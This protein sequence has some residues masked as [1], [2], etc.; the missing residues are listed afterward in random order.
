M[1]AQ[2][3]YTPKVVYDGDDSTFEFPV[4]FAVDRKRDVFVE[5]ELANGAPGIMIPD[6]DYVVR[7]ETDGTLT[8]VTRVD[9]DSDPIATG[10]K[11]VIRRVMPFKQPTNRAVISPIVF[12]NR[13]DSLTREFQQLREQLDRTLH[14]GQPYPPYALRSSDSPGYTDGVYPALVQPTFVAVG[15]GD[16]IL[17]SR[18]GTVYA[19]VAASSLGLNWQDVAWNGFDSKFYAISTTGVVMRSLNS[20]ALEWETMG[21]IARPNNETWS[22]IG[23]NP[24][25]GTIIACASNSTFS[26]GA[27]ARSTNLGTSFSII[28]VSVAK[29]FEPLWLESHSQWAVSQIGATALSLSDDDGATWDLTTVTPYNAYGMGYRGTL[30]ISCDASGGGADRSWRT[31]NLTDFSTPSDVTAVDGERRAAAWG[32]GWFV[33]VGNGSAT[34]NGS[35]SSDGS[36]F[37][38]APVGTVQFHDIDFCQQFSMFSA[39]K[40]AQST[41]AIIYSLDNGVSFASASTPSVTQTSWIALTSNSPATLAG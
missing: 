2:N 13:L 11:I 28:E 16:N 5:L 12:R 37:A 24:N 32:D 20:K 8:V 25:T 17:V 33:Q 29:H 26:G 40:A 4:T 3:I 19:A 41:A 6:Q 21:T 22:G 30:L 31:A 39:L 15:N 1:T 23:C 9:D 18:S 36:V 34:A 27:I 7:E 14:V 10:V 38:Q 35:R